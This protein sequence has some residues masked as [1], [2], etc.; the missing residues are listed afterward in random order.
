MGAVEPVKKKSFIILH[1]ICVIGFLE[2]YGQLLYCLIV[3]S[4]FLQYLTNA[5]DRICS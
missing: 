2:V 3:L 1:S 5:K 4:F